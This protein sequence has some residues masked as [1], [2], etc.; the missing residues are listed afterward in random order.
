M[1]LKPFKL[2]PGLIAFGVIAIICLFRLIEHRYQPKVGDPKGNSDFLSR[3]ES[4]TYDARVKAAAA[5]SPVVATNLGFVFIDEDSV[6]AVKDGSF[7]YSYGMLWP[8]QVY[9]RVVDE[10]MDQ[11]ARTVAFDVIFGELRPEH[12]QVVM[13]DGSG[14]ESDEFFAVQ[15]KRASNVV[16]AITRNVRPP[17]WFQTN[18]W[19]VGHI[20]TDKDPDGILR[21]VQAFMPYPKTWNPLFVD[22]AAKMDT[23]LG[24]AIIESNRIVLP[25]AK[26]QNFEVALDK[27][28]NMDVPDEKDPKAP[29][30]KEKPFTLGRAWH[31]GIVLAASE[32]NLDLDKA[33]VDLPHGRITLRGTNGVERVIPVD[34]DGYFYVDWCM[35]PSHS[36]L[37]VE[38]IQSLLM[39]NFMRLKGE[40]EGITNRWKNRL[41]VV[42]S[43]AVIGNNL[44]DRGATPLEKDT[45]LVSKHWNVANSV[46]TG[47]F[48]DR[49]S[50]AMDMAMIAL[51][52]I[53]AWLLTW[54]TPP[55][56]AVG[57]LIIVAVVYVLLGFYFY[58]HHRYWLPL[59][60]PV[61]SLLISSTLV[62][63]FRVI[64]EQ[65]DKR[66]IRSY[67]SKV[68][69]PKIVQELLSREK[70]SLGGTRR[71]ITV[72]F[73]DIRG[74]TSF[75]D[76][77]QEQ[78]AEYVRANKLTGEAAEKCYDEM[79]T[80]TLE[81]VNLYLGL[82]A[83]VIKKHDGTLDKF[84][85]DCVMAFWS[86][87]ITQDKHASA[88]VR[89]AVDAQRSM[90]ELNKQRAEDNNKLQL[91]NLTRQAAGLPPKP[92]KPILLL[93]TGIN[94]G[95]VTLG[96]MGS[97]QEEKSYTAFGREVNLASRLES[98]SGRGRIFI[99]TTTYEHLKREDPELAATCVEQPGLKLKGISGSVIVYEVPWRPPGSSPLDE[100]LSTTGPAEGT[101]T[102]TSFVQ[103]GST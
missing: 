64:F 26:G 71:E 12:P 52:G 90:F 74:F 87:P 89:A 76:L 68:V 56:I 7:G 101:T 75:T 91:E 69:S 78:V 55:G 86:A 40:T 79:A 3:L 43:S 20:V 14:M 80:Y 93:G 35:P 23:D 48:I 15:M 51:L 63:A 1:K 34:A 73:A 102:F 39:Q 62:I 88:C 22:V 61:I 31:M 11:G 10:L 96:L 5:S 54:R 65:A 47:R 95:V 49:S 72:L 28:G 57:L 36:Q 85:G 59:V 42:G 46:I 50:L 27:D 25:L 38:A 94:T 100:E 9:G 58:V 24:S 44:S 8:R 67:F 21:R 13:A 70:L 18:A 37:T 19:A 98:A 97:A 17:Y 103:R 82:I 77:S 33:D 29:P 83:D 53:I 60:L 41:V 45:L 92:P 2:A 66:R 32:L 16:V 4:V 30:R 6:R 81:T 99:G 84:I